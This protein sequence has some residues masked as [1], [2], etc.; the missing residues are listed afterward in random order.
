[1]GKPSRNKKFYKAEE[2]AELLKFNTLTVYAYI[3][4]KKLKAAK[5]GRNYRIE[6]EDLNQFINDHLVSQKPKE[7]DS[8]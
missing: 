8:Q 1:M 5:F 2:V 4:E 3:R 7:G 6:E